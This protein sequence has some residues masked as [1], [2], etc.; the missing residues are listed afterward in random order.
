M[1]L[2]TNYDELNFMK[3]LCEQMKENENHIVYCSDITMHWPI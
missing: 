1:L 2:A 3:N